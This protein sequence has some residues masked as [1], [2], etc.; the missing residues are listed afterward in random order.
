MP[1][2]DALE[3]MGTAEGLPCADASPASGTTPH[4]CSGLCPLGRAGVMPSNKMDHTGWSSD[5]TFLDGEGHG[6][7]A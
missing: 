7:D 5:M 3:L 1:G 6:Y 2:W 4:Y